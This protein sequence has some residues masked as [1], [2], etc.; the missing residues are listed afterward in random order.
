[1]AGHLKA[2]RCVTV[3]ENFDLTGR[4]PKTRIEALIN[5]TYAQNSRQN[6]KYKI[7]R[8]RTPPIFISRNARIVLMSNRA[9]TVL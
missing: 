7:Y 3:I 6:T 1:M 9:G 4:D 2:V 8:K 5:A